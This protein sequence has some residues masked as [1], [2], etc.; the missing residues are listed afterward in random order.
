MSGNF[1]FFPL[2]TLPP[3]ERDAM[4]WWVLVH[5]GR[6]P[7]GCWAVETSEAH[8]APQIIGK[9]VHLRQNVR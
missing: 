4:Q 8:S 3:V 2:G 7:C 9:L 5:Q 6:I 1:D